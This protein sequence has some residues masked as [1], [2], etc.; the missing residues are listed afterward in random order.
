[1]WKGHEHALMLYC[2]TMIE[3]WV[4]R[5]F[6]NTMRLYA[7]P[8]GIEFPKWIGDDNFHKSHQSNLIRKFPEFYMSKFPGVPNDLPYIWVTNEQDVIN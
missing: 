4:S 5:G 6:N 1:M 8:N 3:E 2:N 7:I